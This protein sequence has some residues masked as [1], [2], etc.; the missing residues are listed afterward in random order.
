MATRKIYKGRL[1]VKSMVEK[2]EV[3]AEEPRRYLIAR[4]SA[5]FN[6]AKKAVESAKG[7]RFRI[8][9]LWINQQAR[10]ERGYKDNV[11]RYGNWVREGILYKRDKKI[12]TPT[13]LCY[14]HADK[15]VE[16]HEQGREYA[17]KGCT[18]DEIDRAVAEGLEI[19]AGDL[20]ANG[21]L[22]IPC[23][24]FGLNK[25][26]LFFFGGKGNDKERSERAGKS[27]EWLINA[28]QKINEVV[29]QLDG[30]NYSRKVG[31]DYAAQVWFR[32]LGSRSGLDGR[33]D[34]DWV[35]DLC[36]AK[37][38]LGVFDSAEGASKNSESN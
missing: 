17:L 4:A 10:E 23:R 31:K 8:P 30:Q 27:G 14:L 29:L 18:Q 6:K 22:V 13:G 7:G 9:A 2:V 36:Y 32:S 35:G 16:A 3:Y 21:N 12:I 25:Y 33:G 38:V 1:G 19:K 34:W 20:D 15:A 24:D 37:E 11:S 5:S 26:G 28:P